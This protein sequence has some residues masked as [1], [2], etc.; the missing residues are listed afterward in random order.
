MSFIVFERP[1]SIL[2]NGHIIAEVKEL[3]KKLK[4]GSL[5]KEEIV[6]IKQ[7]R[8]KSK[9]RKYSL[10]GRQVIK[11]F[12]DLLSMHLIHVAVH[13]TSHPGYQI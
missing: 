11:K 4:N 2:D 7:A 8:R 1:I 6:A 3:N 12:K 5:T 13:T 10:N 9:N